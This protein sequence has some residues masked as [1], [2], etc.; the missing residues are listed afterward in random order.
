MAIC[1]VSCNKYNFNYPNGTVAGSKIVYFPIVTLKGNNAMSVVKGTTFT[2]PGVDAT[3]NGTSVSVT[4]TGS[5]NSNQVGLYVLNYTA[6]NAQGY[7][8]SVQ[9]IVVVIPSAETPGV[10]LS[11]DYAAIGGAPADA[12]ITKID[13]GLYYTTN[14]WGGGSTVVIPAYFISTDGSTLIIPE[15]TSGGV[16]RIETTANGTYSAGLITWSVSRE[17]FPGGALIR[18]KQ[19]QKQ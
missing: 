13:Q 9:R 17:D 16:G 6:A 7:S 11:G 12:T 19:W 5:V 10:D 4:T 3:V 14:C 2:D 18:V 1:L 8:A 15:Q